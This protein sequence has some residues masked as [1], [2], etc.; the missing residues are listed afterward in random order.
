VTSAITMTALGVLLIG[1]AW[2]GLEKAT[3]PLPS[4]ASDSSTAD[5]SAAETSTKRYVRAEDV[6]VSVYN[7][8]ARDG[9]ATL[10]LHRLENRGF[11]A[12]AVGNAPADVISSPV[13]KARVL[14]TTPDD[15]DA[16]LVARNLGSG[17]EVEVVSEPLGPGVDVLVGK[18]MRQL[19]RGAPARLK[20]AEPV[21]SCVKVD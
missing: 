15:P 21:T 12:G 13:N 1:M 3:A 20:L 11:Q 19:R 7:A 16:K 2:W 9:F 8:G 14:T 18:H 4:H 17:V 6:T 5:C 10:T